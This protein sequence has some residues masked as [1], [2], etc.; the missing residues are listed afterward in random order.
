MQHIP[1]TNNHSD[2]STDKGFRFE[3][4]CA[5]CHDGYMTEFQ[6]YTIGAV[7]TVLDMGES[8]FG[9]IF[10]QASDIAH[11]VHSAAWERAKDSAFLEAVEETK[12]HFYRCSRCGSYFC[13]NCWNPDEG[14][15]TNC[16]PFLAQEI[17]SAKR[18]A[19][20]DQA[21]EKVRNIN[22]VTEEDVS[23]DM[24]VTCPECQ[25]PTGKSKFCPNCGAK[26]GVKKICFQC[27]AEITSSVKFCPE[28][29]AKN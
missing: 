7:S 13:K 27:K 29:G 6:T 16:A 24:Q 1:F 9:G 17:E 4:F 20:I 19:A 23:V 2:H 11:K 28:C 21:H 10:H 3:F 14:L 18:H 8:L 25:S 26:L 22:Y 15:C 5:K 12:K